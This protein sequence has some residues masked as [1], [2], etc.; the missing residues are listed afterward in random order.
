MFC[1]VTI[2]MMQYGGLKAGCLVHKNNS[3]PCE[4]KRLI[5]LEA[6]Q[7]TNKISYEDCSNIIYVV[8]EY[9]GSMRRAVLYST[10]RPVCSARI[11]VIGPFCSST[12]TMVSRINEMYLQPR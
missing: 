5:A 10:F 2:R 6:T 1:V 12:I 9:T 4:I 11:K 8:R 3:L 7:S